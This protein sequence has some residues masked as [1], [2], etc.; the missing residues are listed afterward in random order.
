MLDLEEKE[1]EQLKKLGQKFHIPIPEVF[2]ELEVRDKDGKVVQRHKQRSHSWVRNAYSLLFTEMSAVAGYSGN[3]LQ[4]KDTA[5]T[6]HSQT[7]EGYMAG[8]HSI[9]YSKMSPGKPAVITPWYGYR[10]NA[11]THGIVVGSG[12]A[13]FSFENY[14]LQTLIA[15]GTGAGQLSYVDTALNTV[16]DVG[17]V[18]K[19]T[20]I[21]YF[22]NNSGGDIGVNEVGLEAYGTLTDDTAR[23]FMMSRDVLASTVTVPNTG[24]LKVTYIIQLTYPV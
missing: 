7:P 18:K 4:V 16:E 1:Y 24:Q 2:L 20:W 9:G 10:S 17:S 3:N 6:V 15:N 8:A 19:C 14:A 23:K 5:G 12:T 13:A 22:N 21:R 11:D